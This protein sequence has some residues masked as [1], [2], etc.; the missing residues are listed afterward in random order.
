M[1]SAMYRFEPSDVAW[2]SKKIEAEFL[3]I[4]SSKNFIARALIKRELLRKYDIVDR[5]SCIH[6]IRGFYA[7]SIVE[8]PTI[9]ILYRIWNT[10]DYQLDADTFKKALDTDFDFEEI[11]KTYYQE[12]S[13]LAALEI[14]SS[15]YITNLKKDLLLIIES[16]EFNLYVRFFKTYNWLLRI[17]GT[18][19][20]LG[21]NIARSVEVISKASAVGFVAEEECNTLLNQIGEYTE[22][23][24]N[25]WGQ[26]LASCLL[27][28]IFTLF[29]EKSVSQLKESYFVKSVY[30]L[31]NS[32]SAIL[33]ESGLWRTSDLNGFAKVMDQYFHF[34]VSDDESHI[35]KHTLTPED[36][37][38]IALF[39]RAVFSPAIELGIGCYFSASE[40]EGNFYHPLM[41]VGK[42]FLFWEVIERRNS[43]FNII[44]EVDEIPFL[45]TNQATFTNKAIYIFERKMLIKRDL[46]PIKWVD[47]EFN[48]K[49]GYSSEFINV[50]INGHKVGYLPLFARRVGIEKESELIRM[51]DAKL[52][53]LFKKEEFTLLNRL[54]A[55]MPSHF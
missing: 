51:N 22:S 9:M 11:A 47:A 21:Y 48:F 55:S 16:G 39:K 53:E 23:R 52:N 41:A 44:P 15:D 12:F 19:Q 49:V 32:N 31:A 4:V 7:R 35:E 8:D 1:L 36:A 26:Y 2:S 24:F 13:K 42:R 27:G 33:F 46:I 5:E 14:G 34:G 28:K 10:Y 20:L 50:Y 43:R 17:A 54:F 30:G 37:E 6:T 29:E 40:E 3:E 45:L 18:P 25:S 38:A